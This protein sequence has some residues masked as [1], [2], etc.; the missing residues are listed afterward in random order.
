MSRILGGPASD[1]S[2]D[3]AKLPISMGGVGLRSAEDHAAAAFSTS[4]LSSQ[5]MLKSLLHHEEDAVP[6]PLPPSILDLLTAK[7]E[8]EEPM[9]TGSAKLNPKDAQCEG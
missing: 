1:L 4:F 9:S 2:W 8:A 7:T 5:P 3:Q 6:S